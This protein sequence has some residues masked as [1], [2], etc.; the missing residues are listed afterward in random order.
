MSRT[1]QNI[2]FCTSRDGVRI[3]YATCGEGPPLVRAGQWITHLEA[4]WDN[5]VWRPWLEELSRRHTLIRYDMRGCGLSDREGVEFSLER[6]AEDFEAVIEAAGIQRFAL[7]GRRLRALFIDAGLVDVDVHF[8][9]VM[10]TSLTEWSR[11]LGIAEVVTQAVAAG[12]I[13]VERAE[14][15]LSDLSAQDAAGRFLAC[16]TFFMVAGNKP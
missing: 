15:W 13:R 14:A 1:A 9:S 8:F 10:S 3:A 12:R 4:D 16:S 7:L 6:Y 5:L 2:R 11:R